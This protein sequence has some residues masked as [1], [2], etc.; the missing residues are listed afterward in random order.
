MSAMVGVC[1]ALLVCVSASLI[2]FG[3]ER[4]FYPTMVMVFAGNY[5]LFAVQAWAVPGLYWEGLAMVAFSC[6]AIIGFK[7]TNWIVAAAL[8]LHGVFDLFHQQLIVNA[9]VPLWWPVFCSTF[10]FAM[11]AYLAIE[12]LRAR[13]AS[14][15]TDKRKRAWLRSFR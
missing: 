9:G 12:L 1:L 10:D 11:G 5:V 8:V 4:S 7:T 2:G 6:L 13:V 3:R 14:G 15:S